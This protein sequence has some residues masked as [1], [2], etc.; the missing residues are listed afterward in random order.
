MGRGGRSRP[1]VKLR[2]DDLAKE[3]CACDYDAAADNFPDCRGDTR[4]IVVA[5][6]CA[7][8]YKPENQQDA[9]ADNHEFLDKV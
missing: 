1:S 8:V 7:Q 5:E 6:A 3:H 2:A 9:A 4:A